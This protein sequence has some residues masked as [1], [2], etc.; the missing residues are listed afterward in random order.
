M[1]QKLELT[2]A[3]AKSLYKT[4]DDDIKELLEINFGKKTFITDI[5]ERITSFRDVENY[6]KENNLLLHY[7]WDNLKNNSVPSK[8]MLAVLKLEMIEFCLNEGE[9]PKLGETRYYPY[10]EIK[11]SGL[12]FGTSRCSDYLSDGTVAVF[13]TEKLADYAGKTFTDIYEDFIK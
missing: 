2:E 5:T 4:A 7:S 11:S 6:I 3:Q 13:K 12:G 9:I 8:K 10:F 1:K